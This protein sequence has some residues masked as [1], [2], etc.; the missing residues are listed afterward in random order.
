[1]FIKVAAAESEQDVRVVHLIEA[2]TTG[3]R[4][5]PIIG[6]IVSVIQT[7]DFEIKPS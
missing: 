1:M 4:W 2:K 5:D 6:L 3:G 7:N